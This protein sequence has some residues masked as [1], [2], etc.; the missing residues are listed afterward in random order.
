MI[1]SM[2]VENLIGMGHSLGDWLTKD[3][4]FWEYSEEV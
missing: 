1:Q 2:E 4:G 3:L